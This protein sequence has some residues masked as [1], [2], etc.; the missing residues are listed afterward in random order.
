MIEHVL[1]ELARHAMHPVIGVALD[2]CAVLAG[3]V[4]A[5][6]A[7]NMDGIAQHAGSIQAAQFKGGRFKV[8]PVIDGELF[9]CGNHFRDDGLSSAMTQ[10]DRLLKKDV[11]SGSNG[12]PGK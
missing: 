12:L 8:G 2:R 9:S 3:E 7:L 1:E 11:A 10:R 4:V 6:E 5:V